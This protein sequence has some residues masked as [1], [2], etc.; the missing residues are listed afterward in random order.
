MPDPS[1]VDEQAW[2]AYFKGVR[3]QLDVSWMRLRDAY[4]THQKIRAQLGL[5]QVMEP[6][7]AFDAG[8]ISAETEENVLHLQAVTILL[9][10]F[11][12]DVLAGKRKLWFDEPSRDF[13]IELLPNDTLTTRTDATGALRLVSVDT[14]EEVPVTGTVG[15]PW[16]IVAGVAVVAL[17]VY[18]TGSEICDTIRS[19]A[20]E[21]TRQT[22]SN[23]QTEQIKKGASPEQAKALSDSIY[24]GAKQLEQAKGEA[25][26]KTS[27]SGLAGTI[28]TVAWVGLGIAGI[29]LLMRVM[30][31]MRGAA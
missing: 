22:I 29:G 19:Q 24:E 3:D 18:F 13:R 20:E 10:G 2:N 27:E 7:E 23:N 16:A 9:T 25:K 30:P 12:D 8:A 5:K 31:S 1:V 17:G 4:L 14:L 28:R 11:M 6:G 21:A 26:K 15:N